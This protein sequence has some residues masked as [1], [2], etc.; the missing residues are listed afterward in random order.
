MVRNT[1]TVDTMAAVQPESGA[2]TL[3]VSGTPALVVSGTPALV[4]SGAPTLVVSGIKHVKCYAAGLA[5]T[6]I[7]EHY[8]HGYK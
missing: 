5:V 3:V 7:I 6:R 4:V 2:P 1:V 8:V